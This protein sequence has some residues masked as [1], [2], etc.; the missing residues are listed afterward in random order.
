[1]GGSAGGLLVGAAI[2]LAPDAFRAVV[3][4]VPFVDV[5]TTILDPSLP[6]TVGEWEEWGDP[7]HDPEAYRRLKSWSPYDNVVGEELDGSP[8]RY[9]DL[10]VLGSLNDTRVSYWEPAKWTARLRAANP[11]NDVILKTDLGAGH[12][13]PSGRYDSW[14]E[15]AMMFAYLLDRLGVDAPLDDDTR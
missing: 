10:L 4:E 2:N 7:L 12:G 6:L 3:A 9:P 11:S 15:R 5:L 1:M 14:R 13:G 8:R